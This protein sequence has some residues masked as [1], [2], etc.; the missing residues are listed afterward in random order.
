MDQT[1]SIESRAHYRLR[2]PTVDR[3]KIRFEETLYEVS[4]IS[5]GGVRIMFS[6]A[7]EIHKDQPFAGVVHFSDG[8]TVSIEGTVLRILDEEF[9]VALSK[10]VSFNRMIIEQM[11]LRQ[12]YPFLR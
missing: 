9:V 3:P 6:P 4:E 5:E 12:K 1:S 11:R 7:L 8:Q 2:Y 10:G